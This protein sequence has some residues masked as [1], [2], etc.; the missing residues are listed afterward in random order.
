[1]CPFECDFC[2]FWNLEHRWP[3]LADKRDAMIMAYIQRAL[4][5]A[6]WAREPKTVRGNL[7]GMKKTLRSQEV[8]GL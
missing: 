8:L 1:M 3:S 6:F 2:Q 5:D 4:L 7:Y